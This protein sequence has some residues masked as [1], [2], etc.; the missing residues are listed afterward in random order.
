[1]QA[2]GAFAFP[3]GPVIT[4]HN[5]LAAIDTLEPHHIPT[6]DNSHFAD[7]LCCFLRKH[8]SP[9]INYQSS[10][11]NH[12]DVFRYCYDVPV[13]W[14]EQVFYFTAVFACEGF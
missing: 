8:P 7:R 11:I 2:L 6:L 14:A 1:M 3:A 4:R 9:I 10:I 5:P 12:Y 13:A